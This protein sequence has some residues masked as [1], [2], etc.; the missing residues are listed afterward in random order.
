MTAVQIMMPEQVKRKVAEVA[1]RRHVSFDKVVTMA[2]MRELAKLPD[3][4]LERRA[5]RGRRAG[6]DAFMAQV[7]DVPPEDY[8]KLEP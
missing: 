1:H 2:L 8:D 3:Q 4:E 6:F 7:P 5:A